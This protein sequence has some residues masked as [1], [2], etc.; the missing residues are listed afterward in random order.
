M[1]AQFISGSLDGMSPPEN[2][3]RMAKQAPHGRHEMIEGAGHIS[4]VDSAEVFTT[5]LIDFLG[6]GKAASRAQE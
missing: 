6:K 3:S 2:S 1:P 5:H 4:N